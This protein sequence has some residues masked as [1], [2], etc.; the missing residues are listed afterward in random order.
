MASSRV[1]ICRHPKPSA[2]VHLI[3]FPW[4]GGGTVF[5]TNWYKNIPESIQ[6]SAV[7]LAGREFRCKESPYTDLVT[8]IDDVTSAIHTLCGGKRFALFGHSFGGLCVYECACALKKKYGMVPDHVFVS[9]VSAPHSE[10]RKQSHSLVAGQTDEELIN[11]LQRLG[12]T[13]DALINDKAAMKYF[14]PPLKADYH[15]LGQIGFDHPKDRCLLTCPVDVFD[16]DLDSR[17][18]LEAWQDVT[19]GPFSITMMAGGHFYL[20]E[21]DNLNKMCQ[22]IQQ[23]LS[24]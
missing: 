20:K 13:P 2:N 10:V 24:L 6:V 7:C 1:L 9:G 8:F 4:A 5:Y 22:H 17:H 16:G 21:Q 12:G 3:C 15:L 23:A 14:L 19:T 18:D 11:S